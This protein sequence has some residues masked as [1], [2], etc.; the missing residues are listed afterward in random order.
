MFK[1]TKNFTWKVTFGWPVDGDYQDQHIRCQFERLSIEELEGLNESLPDAAAG[2]RDFLSFIKRSLDRVLVAVNM[3][4]IEL[5]DDQG[6]KLSHTDTMEWCKSDPIV[7]VAMY[8]CYQQAIVGR[9]VEV[10]NLNAP[11]SE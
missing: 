11:P 2:E 10:G 3:E 9:K 4:D 5:T 6:D 7:S 8:E 1:P